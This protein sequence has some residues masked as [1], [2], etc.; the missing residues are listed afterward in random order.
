MVTFVQAA[1]AVTPPLYGLVADL[2]GS[3]RTIW[4]ALACVL[5]V[6]FVPAALL[7]ET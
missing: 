6:A 2:S 7:R 1:I 3:Y 4:A 5:L